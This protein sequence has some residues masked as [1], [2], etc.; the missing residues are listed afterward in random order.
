MQKAPVTQI[1]PTI[2]GEGPRVGMTSLIIRFGGC[3]LACP[4]CDTS[5][6]IDMNPDETIF[7]LTEETMDEFVTMLN[8]DYLSNHII[9][10]IMITGGEPFLYPTV[11]NLLIQRLNESCGQ[12][13]IE[14]ETNGVLINHK[15]LSDMF[16][17]NLEE[18]ANITLNISPKLDNLCYKKK[19]TDKKVLDNY[20]KLFDD[21]KLFEI[22]HNRRINRVYKFIYSNG[23]AKPVLELIEK[24]ELIHSNIFFM[25][26]TPRKTAYR[27]EE[28]FISAFQKTCKETVS[29]CLKYG[30][31]YSPR[32]HVFVFGDSKNEIL[33]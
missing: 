13:N 31:R 14:I 15:S 23:M 2:Q 25:P 1:I 12:Y 16:N 6:S 10:N 18:N 8:D 4:F 3:N 7:V 29:A 30:Y 19:T 28:F 32:E 21:I 24:A 27:K 20:V 5:W 17:N 33:E 11:I 22:E 26:F 9:N